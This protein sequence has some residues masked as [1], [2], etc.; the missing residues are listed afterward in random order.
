VAHAVQVRVLVSPYWLAGHDATQVDALRKVG[1]AQLRQLVE[2]GPLQVAQLEWQ[3]VQV[4]VPE[5]L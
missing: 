2:A 5:S 4:L 1:L 3:A